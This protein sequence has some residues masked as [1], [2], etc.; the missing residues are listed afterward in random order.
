M[1]PAWNFDA[2]EHYKSRAIMRQKLGYVQ[3][4]NSIY[5]L[6]VIKTQTYSRCVRRQFGETCC[7]MLK[8]DQTLTEGTEET[9]GTGVESAEDMTSIARLQ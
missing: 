3:H 4:L 6:I 7:D 2:F 9:E 8:T 1:F 5:N